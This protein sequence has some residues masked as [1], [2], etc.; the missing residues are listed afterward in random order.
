M[1]KTDV[2]T[3]APLV[4]SYADGW[5]G[6]IVP[7][8]LGAADRSWLP[9]PVHGAQAVVLLVLDGCGW[10]AVRTAAQYLPLLSSLDGGAISTVVPSTTASALTSIACGVPPA[11][12]GVLG[13][14]VR[15][16]GR[17]L[18]VLR[19]Q[20]QSDDSTPEPAD[21]QRV[22]PFLGQRVPVVTKAEFRK[23]GFTEAHLR[24]TEFSGW[25]TTSALVER[26]R[27]HV[28]AGAPFVYA[29]YDGVDKVAHEYG[30]ESAV[31]TTELTMA[32][33]LVGDLLDRLPEWAALLV[34]ADH[35]QVEVG[36]ERAVAL[37]DVHH[38]VAAYS[39]EGRFRGLHARP[40]TFPDLLD[41]CEQ[42]YGD[43]AWVASRER[44]FD[45]GWFGP[46]ATVETRS[47]LADI[48][49]AARERVVFAD[50]GQPKEVR[51]RAQHGSLTPAEM[52]VPLLAARGRR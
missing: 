13:Y 14:R 35:G 3:P 52:Q 25:K 36:E 29:Y 2:V 17:A 22:P 46:G 39:G 12:H 1:S 34:T 41:A 47:R 30:I 15:I 11:V 50:P 32:D 27:R 42:R 8:L 31:Y 26:V 5:V 33:R 51:M 10:E 44:A 43:R 28:D 24:N 23:T 6:G 20:G 19:W 38:L 45:E 49:L 16:A 37:T 4:P 18:N 21:V 7:A 9:E 48:V 40:G